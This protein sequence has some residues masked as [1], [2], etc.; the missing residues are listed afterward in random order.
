MQSDQSC[1]LI[2]NRVTDR[3]FAWPI[4]NRVTNHQ[5]C[6]Q[7]HVIVRVNYRAQHGYICQQGLHVLAFKLSSSS[8]WKVDLTKV[9][10]F[11]QWIVENDLSSLLAPSILLLAKILVGDCCT[12]QSWKWNN[13]VLVITSKRWNLSLKIPDKLSRMVHIYWHQVLNS[14]HHACQYNWK[15]KCFRETGRGNSGEKGVGSVKEAGEKGTGGG[16]P[17]VAGG[18]RNWK[19]NV[20]FCTRKSTN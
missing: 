15:K 6:G 11:I 16:I 4:V 3:K 12:L 9:C 8:D 7:S 18:R 13:F 2:T 19:K 1:F 20:I 5:L 17:K 14:W 10:R